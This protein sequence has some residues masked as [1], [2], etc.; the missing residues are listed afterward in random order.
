MIEGIPESVSVASSI[1]RMIFFFFF[2]S[3][4]YIALPTPNGSTIIKVIKIIYIVFKMFGSMPTVLRIR[5]GFVVN[6][7]IEM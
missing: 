5:L 1:T 4:K 6:N 2:Y 7:S 3:F